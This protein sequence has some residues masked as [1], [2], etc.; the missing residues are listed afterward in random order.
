MTQINGQRIS[1]LDSEDKPERSRN[2][3]AQARHRA[4]RKAYI[5]QLESTV[6]KLQTSLGKS[7][8]CCQFYIIDRY[9]IRLL[10]GPG[11]SSTTCRR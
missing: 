10:S 7:I 1:H 5:E 8:S 6:T 2:A 9:P 4:K 3:K 11:S